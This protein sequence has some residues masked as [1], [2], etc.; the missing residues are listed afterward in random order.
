MRNARHYETLRHKQF[1][2]A[3]RLIKE[4]QERRKKRHDKIYAILMLVFVFL[5][6]IVGMIGGWLMIVMH[7]IIRLLGFNPTWLVT[8]SQIAL[9][10]IAVGGLLAFIVAKLNP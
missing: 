1:E 7:I 2:K 9:I 6:M 8:S 4:K 10:M 3:A 5:P